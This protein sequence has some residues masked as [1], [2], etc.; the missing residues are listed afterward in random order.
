MGTKNKSVHNY[1]ILDNVDNSLSTT[2]SA[3][4]VLVFDGLNLL[5]KVLGVDQSVDRS[6]GLLVD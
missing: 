6:I 5:V 3:A 2:T 4:A 1:N